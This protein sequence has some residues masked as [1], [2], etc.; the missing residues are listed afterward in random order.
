MERDEIIKQVL[1]KDAHIVN[2]IMGG[3]MNESFIV[4]NRRKEYILYMP[5]VHANEMVNRYLEK[6]NQRIV[7]NLGLTSKNVYFDPDKGIKINEFIKGQPLDKM[8]K[9]DINLDY[10]AGV[11]KYLHN[12]SI[13]CQADYCPFRRL[14]SYEKE[15]NSYIK[16]RSAEY[17]KYRQLLMDNK[18]YLESQELCL[19]HNDAQKSNI[20][21]EDKTNKYYIIDFEFMGNNDPI[22]DIA[23]YGNGDVAEG[24]EL[25][26]AYFGGLETEDEIRRYYLWRLF[27]SLQ[28]HNVALIKHYRGEGRATKF[29]FLDVADYFMKNAQEAYKHLVA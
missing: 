18:E 2:Q 6:D 4:E 23:T 14:E 9:E 13:K 19:C 24:R 3:M 21:K 7:Y 29:N 22:Y 1:G 5:T 26:T 25:L 17:L 11:M 20:I 28:W 16:K 10:V 27:V 8:D 12:S 15:A